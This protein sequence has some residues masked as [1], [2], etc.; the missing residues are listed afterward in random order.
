MSITRS[1]WLI[2]ALMILIF[3]F[4]PSAMAADCWNGSPPGFNF[5]TVTAGQTSVTS[6]KLS[7]SC[8]NYD[9][10]TEYIRACLKVMSNDPQYMHQ[11]STTSTLLYY[12]IYSL[13][14]QHHPL[15]QNSN[16]YAEIN[17]ELA[18]GQAN[19]EHDI[20]LIA[21]I[22]PGQS[23]LS[24]GNYFDY[25][26]TPVQITYASASSEQS[27]PSCSGLSGQTILD[28]I[29]ATATVKDGC[30]ILN[31]DDM[32]F[33]SKSPSE[34]NQLQASSTATI[35]VQCPAGTSYLVSLGHGLHA[36][37]NARSLCH[38]DECVSYNLYQDA[39][40]TEEWSESEPLKQSSSDGQA[41]NLV[42]YGEIP[43]QQWPSA[44]NYSDT[45]LIKVTY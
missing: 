19:V 40:H 5:G 17:L 9:T 41:Q 37:G 1:F 13:Y 7:F 23:N 43:P 44:G 36:E 38:N 21:K 28:T 12:S 14:D 10:G 25:D 30:T 6:T 15:S 4:C 29:G 26:E 20:P 33:G 8:N 27:L 34:D 35:T 32:D 39:A 3:K 22:M 24:A 42:V 18:S 31:A 11:D 16:T 45:V 2:A